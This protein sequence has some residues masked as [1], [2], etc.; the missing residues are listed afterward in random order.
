VGQALTLNARVLRETGIAMD[1]V[2]VLTVAVL[3]CLQACAGAT[4]GAAQGEFDMTPPRGSGV[5]APNATA[6]PTPPLYLEVWATL[7]GSAAGLFYPDVA[8]HSGDTIGLHARTSTAAHVYVMHCGGSARL[9]VFPAS[10]S[11][12]LRADQVVSLPATGMDIRLTGAPGNET[13]YVMASRQPLN[14][15]DPALQAALSRTSAQPDEPICGAELEALLGAR[16]RPG[17]G[18]VR[19]H[20]PRAQ[21]RAAL[22]GIEM[23][24]GSFSVA[25]ALAADDGVIVLRFP[26]RHVP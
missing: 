6:V 16:N 2:R 9:S 14:R 25:R 7:G 3:T 18:Q 13:L 10:G 17:P 21:Q 20:T 5:P 26:F 1:R 11:I 12:D 15:S 4:A 8:L 24:D 19:E 22:R 23:S